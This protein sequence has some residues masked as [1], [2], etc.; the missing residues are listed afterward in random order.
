MKLSL[1]I[2]DDLYD[3]YAEAAGRL[4]GEATAAHMIAAQLDRFKHVD[5][6][7]RVLVV[8]SK[9]R[10]SL[11]HIL[12]G[13]QLTDGANLLKKVQSLA[14]IKIGSIKVSFTPGQLRMI[15]TF[16]ARHGRSI[17]EMTESIV[18]DIKREFL[19]RVG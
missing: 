4:N 2:P 8:D 12:S 5:P 17:Q 13:G 9:S 10:D 7:D 1:Q 19:N 14:D 11:E 15:K 18:A 6:V 16:A 3:V